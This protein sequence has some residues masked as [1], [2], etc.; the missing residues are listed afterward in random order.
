MRVLRKVSLAL[1]LIGLTMPVLAQT[2]ASPT[3]GPATSQAAAWEKNVPEIKFD[4]ASFDD[5]AAFLSNVSG[6]NIVVMRDSNVPP[7]LP[8][9]TC[10]L[11]NVTLSQFANF[12]GT[13]YGVEA[14][15]IDGPS[16]PIVRPLTTE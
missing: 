5:V 4:N 14:T 11:K 10:H 12:L 6:T 15:N 9:V 7:G 3:T 2:S 1:L 13:A 16:G 8:T